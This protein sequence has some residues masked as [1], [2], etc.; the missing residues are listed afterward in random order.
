M[1]PLRFSSS[2]FAIDAAIFIISCDDAF[3]AVSLRAAL[4][5]RLL[6]RRFILRFLLHCFSFIVI[7]MILFSSLFLLR[8]LRRRQVF[9]DFHFFIIFD[10][11]SLHAD[12]QMPSMPAESEEQKE[13]R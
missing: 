2:R 12:A 3:R 6:Q 9:A 5:L 8:C 1:P 13:R 4:L 11:S 7:F 10:A